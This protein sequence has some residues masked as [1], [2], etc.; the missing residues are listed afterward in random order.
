MRHDYH[1]CVVFWV[2]NVCDTD[3]GTIPNTRVCEDKSTIPVKE[4]PTP[5]AGKVAPKGTNKDETIEM[6][7]NL[8]EDVCKR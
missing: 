3:P 4:A 1:H 7:N 8:T 2:T 6:N 5:V